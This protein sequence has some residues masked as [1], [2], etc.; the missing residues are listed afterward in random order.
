METLEIGKY[1]QQKEGFK[2]FI[3]NPFPPKG[4]FNF[5]SNILKKAEQAHNV[6]L[7]VLLIWK[8]LFQKIKIRSMDNRMYIKNMSIF[9]M[10]I[11]N[12]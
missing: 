11:N 8:S 9:F 2:A 1:I 12:L 10:T 3:P 4:G 6:S 5:D 7:I